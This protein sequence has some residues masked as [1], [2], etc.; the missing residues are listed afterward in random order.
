MIAGVPAGS[1]GFSRPPRKRSPETAPS[2]VLSSSRRPLGGSRS[3]VVIGRGFNVGQAAIARIHIR[4][5][6]MRP[7]YLLTAEVGHPFKDVVEGLVRRH[8]ARSVGDFGG[9]A[10]PVLE[11][12]LIAELG[13]RY[14]VVDADSD[15]LA[16]TPAGYETRLLDLVGDPAD[17]GRERFDLVISRFVAEHVPD[18]SA[19]H[20]SVHRALAPGGR[21]THFFPT[22]PSPPFMVN[23]LL[24]GSASRRLLDLLQPAVRNDGGSLRKFPAYY[25]WCE[26]PTNRQRRRLAGAGF[27]VEQ[28][29]SL[30]GH[31][32]Y[33]RIPRLQSAADALSRRLA[34]LEHPLVTTYAYVVLRRLDSIDRA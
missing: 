6:T 33:E 13:L 12:G 28:Y 9:G 8:G 24:N 29:V 19:F 5:S 10:N 11:L 7:E 4:H 18:P 1:F 20:R 2:G 23:R 3:K 16:K 31:L 25:R 17:L 30:V 22:L 15:E 14:V 26:G 21:A 32:Y 34:R 27:A